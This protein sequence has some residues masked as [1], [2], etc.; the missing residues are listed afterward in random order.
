MELRA[1]HDTTVALGSIDQGSPCVQILCVHGGGNVRDDQG[2]RGR[3]FLGGGT[4]FVGGKKSSVPVRGIE[5]ERLEALDR[6]G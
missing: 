5:S 6:R 3:R 2:R 4:W 1:I